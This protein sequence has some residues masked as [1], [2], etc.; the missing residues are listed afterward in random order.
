MDGVAVTEE[1][2]DGEPAVRGAS[3]SAAKAL[4]ADEYHAIGF[5]TLARYS[6]ASSMGPVVTITYRAS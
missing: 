2:V 4:L 6:S 1:D 3:T 5:P